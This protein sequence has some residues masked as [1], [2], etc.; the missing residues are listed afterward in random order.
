MESLSAFLSQSYQL[1]QPSL[2]PMEGYDSTN[3]RVQANGHKYVLKLYEQAPLLLPLLGAENEVLGILNAVMPGN[4]PMPLTDEAGRAF[5]PFE[6]Q[7]ARLLSFLEGTFLAEVEHTPALFR[8]FGGFLARMNQALLDLRHPAIEARRYHWDL[9]HAL[10]NTDLTAHISDAHKRKWAD[11][12]F[13]QFREQVSPHIRNLRHAVI[14]ADAND[15]NVLTHEGQ[16]SG[17][18]DFGDMVYAPLVN[19]LAIAMA[20][21]L[22]EKAEPLEWAAYLVE[23]YQA[24]LPLT[25]TELGL[26]YYLVGARLAV[27]VSRSAYTHTQKPDSE[28]ITISEQ[29]A[30]D[31]MEKWVA[32]SPEAAR[33]AFKQAAGFPPE[34]V[35]DP[36]PDLKRR[37][38]FISKSLSVSFQTPIQMSG[39]AFQYMF[40]TSGNTYLDAYNNIPHVGHCH[41]HVVAA[42]QRQMAQLNTNTRYLYDLLPDYAERL[43]NTFPKSLNRIFFVNSGSAASDLAIRLAMAHTQRQHLLVMEHGYHGHTRLGIDISSY[44]F[45]GKGGA[46]QREYIFKAPIPDAY[47]GKYAGMEDAGKRFAQDAIQLL[48]TQHPVA[49]FISEPVVGCGGQVPLAPGYL[50]AMYAAIRKQGGLC[51]SDEVQAG[52]GRLGEWFWGFEMH[53]VVPDIVVMGKPMGN[54]HPMAAVV[55][56]EAVAHSFENGM[57][58]FS[59]FG[60]N[61]VSCAIGMAVLDVME[62]EEL[63]RHAYETGIYLK[64]RI[65]DLQGRFD[66][67]GDVR[68][69]GLF[70]GAELVLDRASKAPNTALAKHIKNTMKEHFIL[71]GTD[72]PADNV[73]KIKPP[74]SFDRNNAD[75][76]VEVLEGSLKGV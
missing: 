1:P 72:G 37:H 75:Q 53:A 64:A 12:F 32:I 62:A 5:P 38:Q 70:L 18:I 65:R 36:Q 52:F 50:T 57:E 33:R 40:D 27:S 2:T 10:V 26:L 66:A 31:L 43:L 46:G 61:P 24:V 69:S 74:L 17:L 14:H 25:E 60:G 76:F 21:A 47:K 29:P 15:W 68:G 22:F 44:K 9:T 49:A 23:G 20:Y 39:A 7:H 16:I 45:E 4:F 6:D 58:F 42:G 8:H 55:T 51:I 28:Y 13:L 67:I 63:Q 30:W 73:L 71:V 48:N 41:P 54:G 34:P 35:Y 56:T 59:S 3:F 11:Y 19:E